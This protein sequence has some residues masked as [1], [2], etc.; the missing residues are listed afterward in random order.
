MASQHPLRLTPE[1]SN[2]NAVR[3]AGPAQRSALIA[4]RP[5]AV[6]PRRQDMADGQLVTLALNGDTRAFP[7]LM[8]R[9]EGKL[10]GL[11]GKRVRIAED[12]AD[13]AQ[14]T[15]LSAWA[16][17]QSY[18]ATQ[19]FET[20]LVCIALNKCRDWG[21]RRT[22]RQKAAVYLPYLEQAEVCDAESELIAGE[23]ADHFHQA[24]D[25]LPEALRAP[26]ILTAMQEMKHQDAARALGITAKGVETRVRRA[27]LWLR[28]ALTTPSAECAPA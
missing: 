17:L 26:L 16:A 28:E 3:L 14:D 1:A 13:L 20:W 10:R 19:P 5:A 6:R 11:I 8:N 24:L 25:R 4:V 15:L 21:R 23:A 12:A 9:Y 27:K 22:V 2:S 18:P 7:V